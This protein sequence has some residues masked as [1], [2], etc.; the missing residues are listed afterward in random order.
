MCLLVK[1]C[2]SERVSGY[3]S[4]CVCICECVRVYSSYRVR[5]SDC[6]CNS[7]CV[8]EFVFGGINVC[9]IVYK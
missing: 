5:K 9:E 4:M 8:R 6:E 1:V 3:M 7:V 2:L